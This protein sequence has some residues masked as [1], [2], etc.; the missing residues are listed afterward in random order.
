MHLFKPLKPSAAHQL[1]TLSLEQSHAKKRSD[2]KD[3]PF[4]VG[5]FWTTNPSHL[6]E[7]FVSKK[8]IIQVI[9]GAPM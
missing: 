9:P 6:V 5:K 2:S 7:K 1:A 4:F 3:Q 8:N